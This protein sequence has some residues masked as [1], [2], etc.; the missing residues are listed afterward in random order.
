MTVDANAG[1]RIV[2]TIAVL[3]SAPP[4]VAVLLRVATGASVPLQAWLSVVL[5]LGMAWLL[6]RGV[7]WARG[8]IIT[9]FALSGFAVVIQLTLGWGALGTGATIAL[10]ATGAA[11]FAGAW[12]LG[13][14]P[15]VDAY[16]DRENQGAA[17]NLNSQG[18]A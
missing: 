8:L 11:Y 15:R 17:L 10:V 4:T 12:L 3:T 9:G 2:R 1:G 18:G 14:S 6:I 16:F 5:S 13:W 7:W